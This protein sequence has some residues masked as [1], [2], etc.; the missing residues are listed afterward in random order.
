VSAAILAGLSACENY[1]EKLG[2]VWHD[3]L[4]FVLVNRDACLTKELLIKDKID[5]NLANI[6]ESE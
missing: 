4:T 3:L 5:W 1:C 6:S 2:S